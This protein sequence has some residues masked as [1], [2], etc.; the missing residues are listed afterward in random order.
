MTV[1]AAGVV[2]YEVADRPPNSCGEIGAIQLLG[3]KFGLSEASHE[4]LR[5][6]K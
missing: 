3:R 1:F 2:Q 6:L 4:R 5:L